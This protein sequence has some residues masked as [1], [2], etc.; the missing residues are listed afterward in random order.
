MQKH[1]VILPTKRFVNAEEA[2]LTFRIELK[3]EQKVLNQT[4]RSVNLNLSEQ[5]NKERQISNRFRLTGSV[6][7]LWSNTSEVTLNPGGV[8]LP[9][10]VDIMAEMFL[11][12]NNIEDFINASSANTL[13]D[14]TIDQVSGWI[15]SDEMDFIR[16]DYEGSIDPNVLHLQNNSFP[17][18]TT[19]N[20][21]RINWE[22]CVTYTSD[23]ITT[24]VLRAFD[25]YQKNILGGNIINFNIQDGLPYHM[26]DTGLYYEFYCPFGHNL[27]ENQSVYISGNTYNIDLIGNGFEGFDNKIFYII[28]SEVQN[29]INQNGTF[30]R[31]VN[32]T[33]S[34]YYIRKHK[35]LKTFDD[36][37]IQPNGFSSSIFEDEQKIPKYTPI[38]DNGSFDLDFNQSKVVTRENGRSYMFILGD[39][40]DVTNMLDHNDNPITEL[41]FTVNFK[42]KMQFFGKQTTSFEPNTG[43]GEEDNT[44]DDAEDLYDNITDINTK[45]FNYED[46]IDGDLCEY[47]DDELIEYVI[48]KRIN[49]LVYNSDM[50]QT[51]TNGYYYNVHYPYTLQVYSPYIEEGNRDEIYN[52]PRNAKFDQRTQKWRWRDIYDKG[53]I[54]SDGN[55]VDHPYRNGSHY[56]HK[57]IF[58]YIKPDTIMGVTDTLV[59]EVKQFLNDKC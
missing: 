8:G 43:Y 33:I 39:Y 48:Q 41:Y 19:L 46:E 34:E 18:V 59:T 27:N 44:F 2:D 50:F 21:H 37:D 56:L 14:M 23:K 6:K 7:S 5:F 29:V 26:V 51:S 11:N 25:G 40:V 58:F 54:D 10:S 16:N 20:A 53:F 31:V 47:N 12:S 4:D 24:K 28:K 30:K 3:S 42:N 52:I 55:G 15:S 1:T 57:E 38:I 35:V 9:S 13:N 36:L 17:K 22:L 49:R 32:N 45:D